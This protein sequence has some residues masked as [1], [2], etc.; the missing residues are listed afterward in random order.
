MW[1]S[2]STSQRWASLQW[3]GGHQSI[4]M[5]TNCVMLTS[6]RYKSFKTMCKEGKGHST[7]SVKQLDVSAWRIGRFL[8]YAENRTGS[9]CLRFRRAWDIWA[10]SLIQSM[11]CN[12]ECV[13][14]VFFWNWH[15][16]NRAYIAR[17]HWKGRATLEGSF[18][19]RAWIQIHQEYIC[20]TGWRVRL[21][22]H[23]IRLCSAVYL[24]G[25]PF[26]W[27]SQLI[28]NTSCI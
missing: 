1:S 10:A 20:R 6:I 21:W 22:D 16:W 15:F 17:A 11:Y 4:R 14:K 8:L 13:G 7:T 28:V 18:Q 3:H 27:D 25:F 26:S 24:S 23:T 5:N 12:A 9:N 19:S 2:Q